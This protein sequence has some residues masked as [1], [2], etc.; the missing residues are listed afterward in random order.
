MGHPCPP[1]QAPIQGRKALAVHALVPLNPPCATRGLRGGLHI[2]ASHAYHADVASCLMSMGGQLRHH[3]HPVAHRCPARSLTRGRAV[4]ARRAHNPE[5]G[6][7]NPLPAT[8]GPVRA[9]VVL[10]RYARDSIRDHGRVPE[11]YWSGLLSRRS[12]AGVQVRILSLPPPGNVKDGLVKVVLT[13]PSAMRSGPAASARL[14][15]T[16]QHTA[17][18]TQSMQPSCGRP[19]SFLDDAL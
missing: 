17:R 16:S 7:S 10:C 11:R 18:C 4:A 15:F 1:D 19:V 6:G 14:L 9:L 5:V 8:A 12:F 2:T 3:P 13:R